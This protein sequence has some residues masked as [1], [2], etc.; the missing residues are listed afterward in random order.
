MEKYLFLLFTLVSLN[1]T[2]CDREG[3]KDNIFLSFHLGM[4]KDE[5]IKER[6][7]L[8]KSN[9][10]FFKELKNE[11]VHKPIY[12]YNYNLKGGEVFPV[13]IKP[14]F[15]NNKLTRLTLVF[16][17]FKSNGGIPNYLNLRVNKKNLNVMYDFFQFK[18]GKSTEGSKEKEYAI[19]MKKNYE[20]TFSFGYD[21]YNEIHRSGAEIEWKLVKKIKE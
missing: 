7:L 2:S 17:S 11:S 16:V 10:I 5:Y 14:S 18:F 8:M 19:W 15:E 20:V 4:T 1:V 9:E 3:K 12:F 21:R 13:R 6:N